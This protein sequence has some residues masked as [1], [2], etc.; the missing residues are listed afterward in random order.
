M[1]PLAIDLY[2]GLGGWAEGFLANNYTVIGFDIERHDYGT[3]GYP[4]HLVLQDVREIHG[5][6]FNNAT[7]IV[8]SPPCTEYA[9]MA[10]PWSRGK[11][12]QSALLGIDDFPDNYHGSRTIKQLNILFNECFRIRREA[13]EAAGRCIPLVIENVRGAEKWVGR[14]KRHYGP[15]YLW[16]DI[17]LRVP[18]APVNYRKGEGSG[19]SWFY[20]NSGNGRSA[21]SHSKERKMWTAKVS[22]IPFALANWIA[23]S[24]YP[25]NSVMIETGKVVIVE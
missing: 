13:S 21:S 4:G 9:Y 10:M 19:R 15:Q 14:A 5:R 7:V 6:R 1:K 12:V 24:Y 23:G 11:Q 16:G 20:Q 3:G 22:K 25:K 18:A 8:A 2:A 17:P